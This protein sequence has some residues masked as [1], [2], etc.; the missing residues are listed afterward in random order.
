MG[1]GT[2]LLQFAI[3]QCKGTPTLWILENNLNAVRFYRRMGFEK[4]GNKKP[5]TEGL[6]EIEYALTCA[7]IY[8]GM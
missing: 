8:G 2:Q 3:G 5:I 7:H 6:D 4:T 1:Y